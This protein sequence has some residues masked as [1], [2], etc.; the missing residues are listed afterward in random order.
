[1]EVS[2]VEIE[3][4]KKSEEVSEY[5]PSHFNDIDLSNAL[6]DANSLANMEKLIEVCIKL[7]KSPLNLEEIETSKELFFIQLDKTMNEANVIGGETE[8]FFHEYLQ[9]LHPLGD[10]TFDVYK[11]EEYRAD[12]NSIKIYLGNFYKFF[13]IS[14]K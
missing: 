2:S 8:S 7:E 1:M 11:E 12:L 14:E 10:M 4:V 9:Q 5:I 3:E 13:P 6:V